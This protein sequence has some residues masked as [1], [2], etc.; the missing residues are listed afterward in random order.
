MSSQ[1]KVILRNNFL[2]KQLYMMIIYIVRTVRFR[3][4]NM[5]NFGK[6]NSIVE[7]KCSTNVMHKQKKKKNCV[8]LILNMM[9]ERS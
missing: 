9:N 8:E 1:R 6:G 2:Q 4:T 3:Q 7:T 5:F